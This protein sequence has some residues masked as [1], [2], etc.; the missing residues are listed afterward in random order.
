MANFEE[1][2]PT[3]LLIGRRILLA[4]MLEHAGEHSVDVV[5]SQL[6]L[7]PHVD[8]RLYGNIAAPLRKVGIIERTKQAPTK[9]PGN[10]CRPIWYYRLADADAARRWLADN[11]APDVE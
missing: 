5:L 4:Y 10:H 6:K 7:P 2:R 3:W 8:S 11:P 1:Y 9:K